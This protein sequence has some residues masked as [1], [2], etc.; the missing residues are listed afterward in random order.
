M[1]AFAFSARLLVL[2]MVVT[3]SS[4]AWAQAPPRS[5]SDTVREFYKALR[6]KRFRDA[7]G[8]SIYKPAI[9]GLKPEEFDD[10]RP[11]FEKVAGK[12]P[13]KV[14]ISGEQISGEE[15]AVFVKVPR[16]DDPK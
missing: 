14:D 6:E 5:P 3:L 9:D 1:R 16:E 15:A 7:F 4:T 12:I 2:A 11:D 8:M 13:E 10:L